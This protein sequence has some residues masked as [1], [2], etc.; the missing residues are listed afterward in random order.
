MAT[1]AQVCPF[2][3]RR[4]SFDDEVTVHVYGDNMDEQF[5]AHIRCTSNL[6]RTIWHMNGQ[7]C[8][9]AG[10]QRIVQHWKLFQED[11]TQ[12]H[13]WGT[14]LSMIV[15]MGLPCC[16]DRASSIINQRIR[17]MPAYL[18]G[19]LDFWPMHHLVTQAPR[20]RQAHFVEVWYLHQT[21][22]HVCLQ[23]RRI[24]VDLEWSNR[25][26]M[27]SMILP[28]VHFMLLSRRQ[29]P[30]GQPLHM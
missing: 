9:L 2:Q 28:S 24:R 12:K 23:P 1:D 8:D 21:F 30:V 17:V 25:G 10:A 16:G 18:H 26:L 4:V 6:F 29:L 27:L 14:L 7:T 22:H 20:T 13:K 3:V 15:P 5:R 19:E 11:E